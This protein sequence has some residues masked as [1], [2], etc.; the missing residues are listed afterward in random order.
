MAQIALFLP[1]IILDSSV[2]R[3]AGWR[4]AA[5]ASLFELARNAQIEVIIPQMAYEE[6]RTQ[7]REDYSKKIKESIRQIRSARQDPLLDKEIFEALDLAVASLMSVADAEIASRRLADAYFSNGAKIDPVEADDGATVMAN[8]LAGAA[9]FSDVKARK[10]IPDAYIYEAVRRHADEKHPASFVTG[11]ENL[12][13]AVRQIPGVMVFTELS[14]L[15]AGSVI[16]GALDQIALSERWEEHFEQISDQW[17]EDTA[18][19]FVEDS[20]IGF[21]ERVHIRDRSIPSEGHDASVN[22]FYDIEDFQISLVSHF[23]N[24]WVQ[25]ECEFECMVVLSFMVH[26]SAAYDLPEWVSVSYGDPEEE[27]YFDAEGDRRIAVKLVLAVKMDSDADGDA[28]ADSIE[29]SEP[30]KVELLDA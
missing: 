30:P 19:E 10:D 11:D 15:M 1:K 20:Y 6:R 8:Y 25:I 16:I 12:A 29:L 13:A 18:Q 3:S 4:S 14:E 26:K 28:F 17:F 9:P 5:V 23:G 24:G 7:W 27:H 2:L 21:L 22:L